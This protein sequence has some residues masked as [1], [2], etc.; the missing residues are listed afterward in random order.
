MTKDKSK[1]KI[2]VSE[3][4]LDRR[5]HRSLARYEAGTKIATVL[6]VCGCIVGVAYF[7]VYLQ[8]K[9]SRGEETTV[10]VIVNWLSEFKMNVALAW[11]V[12]GF[13]ALYGTAMHRKMIRERAAK[14]ARIRKLEERLDAGVSSSKLDPAGTSTTEAPS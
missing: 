1:R 7:G 14:D 9:A 6:C 11:G 13:G 12:G 3:A 8:V 4:E 10:T 5:H 2:E